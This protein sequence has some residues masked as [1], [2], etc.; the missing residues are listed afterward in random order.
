MDFSLPEFEMSHRR[1]ASLIVSHSL[2]STFLL[3]AM[4]T[5]HPVG[6]NNHRCT[7][8]QILRTGN[9]VGAVTMCEK[10]TCLSLLQLLYCALITVCQTHAD[11]LR[12]A[13]GGTF[14][15]TFPSR[16]GIRAAVPRLCSN[17]TA[18]PVSS[19]F[20]RELLPVVRILPYQ[21][22]LSHVDRLYGRT[23]RNSRHIPSRR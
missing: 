15:M 13:R 18:S 7:P 22:E 19:L 17:T 6:P 20:P 8:H 5:R 23:Q 4:M 21:G 16:A 2:F 1:G 12:F 10:T 9:P 14:H 3:S 11:L